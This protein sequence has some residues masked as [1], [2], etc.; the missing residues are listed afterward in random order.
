VALGLR[1]AIEM[2]TDAAEGLTLEISGEGAGSLPTDE[3]NIT[4]KAA[5]EVFQRAHRKPRGLTIR[6]FNA[7]PPGSGLGSSA[8][9]LVGGIVAAN[10]LADTPLSRDDLLYLACE[11]EGHPDNVSAALLGGLVAS[12]Y[13]DDA[14]VARRIPIAS[15][16]VAV[17]LPDVHTS[18]REM[19]AALPP[20]V[21]LADAVANI[22]RAVLVVQALAEGD[23]DLL[24]QVM[25]DRLHEP[26]RRK[27][28]P[29]YDKVVG[30]ALEAG[31]S[32]VAISGAGP[33]LIAF[34]PDSHKQI[35]EAMVR[36]LRGPGGVNAR[37]WVLPVDLA[38]VQ[39]EA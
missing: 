37:S 10:A 7:I 18:T 21:A 17:A 20:T 28:I 22:G 32:A 29:G 30:A 36:A 8:A 25:K 4:V 34:A 14:L 24:C 6:A 35:A 19:R 12:S 16:K 5:R 11:L 1:N 15:M 3:T 26:Y 23:F 39:I 38:G 13:T 9:A 33:A 31:A 27:T 2:E